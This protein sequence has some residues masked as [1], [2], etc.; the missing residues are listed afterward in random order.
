[1]N[2]LILSGFV[3]GM[4]MLAYLL[5]YPRVV[6]GDVTRLIAADVALTVVSLSVVGAK[7]W[8]TDTSFSFGLFETNWAVATILIFLIFESFFCPRYCRRFGIDLFR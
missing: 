2:T 5:I 6:Q 4:T 8:G 3:L 7:F 1:M